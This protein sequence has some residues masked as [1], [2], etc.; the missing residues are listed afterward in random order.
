V[1]APLRQITALV[2]SLWVLPAF[3]VGA[4]RT[5]FRG[6]PDYLIDTWEAENGW[7]GSSVNAVAQTPDGYLW[8]GTL[9]GLVRFDGVKFTAFD[10]SSVPELPHS[11]IM[12]LHLDRLGRLWAGTAGG[13]A[14]RTGTEWRE[15]A[16][17]GT[18][19]LRGGHV[20]RSLAERSS[21]EV[22]VTTRDGGV[23]EFRSGQLHA[24]P[25]PPGESQEAGVGCADAVGNWWVAQPKFI[26]QW[27][28]Q[29]WM[30]TVSLAAAGNLGP[31]QVCCA[32]GRVG[33]VW[34]VLGSELRHYR[35]G[36][37]TGRT[38]LPGFK[39][40]VASVLEDSRGNV[41]IGTQGNGLWQVSSNRLVRQW[42]L[43]NGL[44]D[45]TL[46][47]VFEDRERNVWVGTDCGSLTRFKERIFQSFLTVTNR[48][49]VTRFALAASPT[50]GVGIACR[51]QGVW[52]AEADGVANV[53]LPKPCDDLCF[54]GLS[55]LLDRAGVLWAG[56]MTNGVWRVEGQKAQWL[57]IDDSGASPVR[58]LRE[59]SRGRVWMA[60]GQS[61]SFFEA[62]KLHGFGLAE[63]LPAGSVGAVAE[64]RAG[65]IWLAHAR[66]L[67]RLDQNRPL[68]TLA[69]AGGSFP[70][71]S[72]YEDSDGALWVAPIPGGLACWDR[73]RLFRKTLPPELPMSGLRSFQ[74][75]RLG[76]LWMTSHQGV[77]RAHKHELKAWLEGKQPAVAWRAFDASDG[78]PGLDCADSARDGQGRLWFATERGVA[79]VDPAVERPPSTPPRVQIEE[80]TYHRTARQ[81]YAEGQGT[82]PPPVRSRLE[83]PFPERLTLPPGSR[84]LEV[85]YTAFDFTAPE[86]LRFQ[87][88]LEPGDTEWQNSGEQ[89]VASFYDFDPGKY[90]FHVRAVK[91]DGVWNETGAS[92][93]FTVQPYLWQ[94]A[95]FKALVVVSL[96]AA[97]YVGV[98]RR[99]LHLEKARA[100]QQSFT[101]RLLLSQEIERKRVATELHDG[102]GQN[103]LLI[104]NRLVMATARKENPAELA[105]QLDAAAAATSRAIDEMRAISRALRPTALEQVGLTKAIE[106]MVEQLGEGSATKFAADLD[107]VDGLLSPE[108]EINLYRIIQEGLNNIV[109][110]A[111]AAEVILEM[112]REGAGLRVSLFD[113]GSGFDAEKLRSDP[114]ARP[115]LGLA[116]LTERVH[117]L[118]GKLDLQSAPGRGTRL[119]VLV[120]LPT[121]KQDGPV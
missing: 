11:A 48:L 108:Q 76:F 31:D 67:L 45:N 25:P 15:V 10:K 58:T 5:T 9:R 86:K 20:I 64:D 120:P 104:K 49:T 39:G 72:L 69:A 34:L 13:L 33:G 28:G 27:D 56:A 32:A 103:L 109:R 112:K 102:L 8:L 97:V 99:L 66:G 77:L 106:W 6:D 2:A 115:G 84:R 7:L 111:G 75:D 61:L 80:L 78:L 23:L 110:H 62:G 38:P 42:S 35:G 30:E 22:L 100:A 119:T 71:T 37:E 117:F 114:A 1:F 118:G 63:G 74:E 96:A 52:R 29:R 46:R 41:W 24:L 92:L 107:T 101:Q 55:L 53:P 36:T 91:H 116:S 105:S 73:G 83:S 70:A 47:C 65:T 81:V 50:G 18:N 90:V 121:T 59:D 68:H 82:A 14:V 93:A 26:G 113:N 79:R 60:G 57:T 19:N 89:R 94:T 98:R 16:L 54:S 87:T 12:A 4:D 44:P 43:S 51:T 95:W 85:H 88:R 40:R 3:T 17:P 21:G